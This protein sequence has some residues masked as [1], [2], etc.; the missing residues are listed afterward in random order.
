MARNSSPSAAFGDDAFGPG[1]YLKGY[2]PGGYGDFNLV[3]TGYAPVDEELTAATED[4]L[5]RRPEIS[6]VIYWCDHA[7][8]GRS[9]GLVSK[10]TRLPEHLL[11]L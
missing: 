6:G 7:P 5:A 10:T 9:W 11:D 2:L 1:G 8:T 3:A 4:F